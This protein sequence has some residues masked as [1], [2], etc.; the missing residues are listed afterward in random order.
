MPMYEFECVACGLF[1]L[2]RSIGAWEN[3]AC[4]R[5]G[6]HAQRVFT[7]PLLDRVAAPL[8]GALAREERSAHH[9]E[10]IRRPVR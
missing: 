8:R 7:A 5:C 2:Q 6:V 10:V 4:V 9:P 3:V 1:E